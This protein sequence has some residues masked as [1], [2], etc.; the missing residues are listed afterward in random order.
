MSSVVF[1]VES[2][3]ARVHLNRPE[4]LNAITTEMDNAL[5]AA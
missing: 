1:S 2:H 5:A 4:A 3:L